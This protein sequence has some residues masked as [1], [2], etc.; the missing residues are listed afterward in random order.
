MDFA[1]FL[2]GVTFDEVGEHVI[3][4][5]DWSKMMMKL[6]TG[7]REED[8]F[9]EFQGNTKDVLERALNKVGEFVLASDAGTHR[10]TIKLECRYIPWPMDNGSVKYPWS[11]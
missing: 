7:S 2:A 10:S 9:A 11:Y 3:K 8:V 4:E 5:L 6:R 1:S